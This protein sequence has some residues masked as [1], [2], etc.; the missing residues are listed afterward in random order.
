MHTF[1]Q[2]D[3]ILCDFCVLLYGSMLSFYIFNSLQSDQII[4]LE[5]QKIFMLQD[6]MLFSA[7]YGQQTSQLQVTLSSH[8][9]SSSS[10]L[11]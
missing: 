1:I 9:C 3:T 11:K 10:S 8:G 7:N 2:I 5:I 4:A 6:V